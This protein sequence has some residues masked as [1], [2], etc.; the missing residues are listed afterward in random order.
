MNVFRFGL[1]R[2]LGEPEWKRVV[3][4][5]AKEFL[6]D[7]AGDGASPVSTE[8]LLTVEIRWKSCDLSGLTVSARTRSFD[9]FG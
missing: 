6:A 4:R 8:T 7:S 2:I 1:R 3:G 5:A 9:K